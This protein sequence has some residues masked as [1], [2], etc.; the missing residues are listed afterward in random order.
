MHRRI[1][2]GGS[3]GG[4]GPAAAM[5]REAVLAAL[6]EVRPLLQADGGD[7]DLV[8]IDDGVV[9]VRLEVRERRED[10]GASVGVC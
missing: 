2:E 6:E 1:G 5:T 10:G 3:G 7:I 9:S 4:D 8:G